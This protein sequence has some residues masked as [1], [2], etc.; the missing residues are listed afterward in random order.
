MPVVETTE[1]RFE[2]DIES[3]LLSPEGGYTNDTDTYEPDLGLASTTHIRF[4]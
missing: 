2:A 1:K 3:F 4:I